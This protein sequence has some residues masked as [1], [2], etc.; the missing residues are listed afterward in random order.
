MFLGRAPSQRPN[1]SL[2]QHRESGRIGFHTN[3]EVFT[4]E[5]VCYLLD[6]IL[7]IF[8]PSRPMPPIRPFWENTKA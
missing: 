2:P 6:V 5:V 8:D 1:I 4:E 3:T 7:V